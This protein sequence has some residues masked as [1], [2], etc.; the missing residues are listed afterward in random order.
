MNGIFVEV[1]RDCAAD[2]SPHCISHGYGL[3]YDICRRSVHTF[4]SLF[5]PIEIL[6]MSLADLSA[7]PILLTSM[8]IVPCSQNL[9]PIFVVTSDRFN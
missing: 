2:C 1:N 8:L 3:T 4:L 5:N 6:F 9:F 7:L